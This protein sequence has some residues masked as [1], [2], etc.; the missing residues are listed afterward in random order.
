MQANN[1]PEK[2]DD[3]KVGDR[4]I[5]VLK[6][7][8]HMNRGYVRYVGDLSGMEG[9]YYGIELDEPKGVHEGKNYFKT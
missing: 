5:I 7:E 8:N 1:F 6:K 3:I 4:I 2:T 9:V